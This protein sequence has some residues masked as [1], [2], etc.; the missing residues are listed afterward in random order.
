M[1]KLHHHSKN[2]SLACLLV[3][4]KLQ[5]KCHFSYTAQMSAFPVNTDDAILHRENWKHRTGTQESSTPWTFL[6]HYATFTLGFTLWG[7]PTEG[8]IHNVWSIASPKRATALQISD[9]LGTTM[10][11]H[12]N[13]KSL[14]VFTKQGIGHTMCGSCL[15]MNGKW[16]HHDNIGYCNNFSWYRNIKLTE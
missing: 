15:F 10:Y 1:Y 8:S 13:L 4:L 9:E 12:M 14:Q 2:M 3:K 11:M 6:M 7:S 16:C 5:G